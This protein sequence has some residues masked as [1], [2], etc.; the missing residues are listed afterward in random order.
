MGFSKDR[1]AAKKGTVAIAGY[2]ISF[3]SSKHSQAYPQV[4]I[5]KRFL[6]SPTL[7]PA[8]QAPNVHGCVQEHF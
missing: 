3:L 6:G 1:I 5:Q 7:R 4:G 2:H 8:T